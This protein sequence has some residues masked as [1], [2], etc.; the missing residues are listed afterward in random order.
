MK[1][2]YIYF[3]LPSLAK[4]FSP[5]SIQFIL[6]YLSPLTLFSLNPT[7]Q[8]CSVKQCCLP[9][10]FVNRCKSLFIWNGSMCLK[11]SQMKTFRGS[12]KFGKTHAQIQT[13]TISTFLSISK[14]WMH[15]L[16]AF[17]NVGYKTLGI[18]Q[19]DIVPFQYSW[20][21]KGARSKSK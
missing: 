18:W 21:S 17:V 7:S 12:L 13:L 14:R 16:N 6:L 5:S 9:S 11:C 3:I 10:G 1:G 20:L 8:V 2:D 15:H 19:E 4:V